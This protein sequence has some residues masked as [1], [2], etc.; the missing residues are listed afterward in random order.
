MTE[1]VASNQKVLNWN[2]KLRNQGIPC[3]RFVFLYT[4]IS[5]DDL[6]VI[7]Q[8]GIHSSCGFINSFW[9][10]LPLRKKVLAAKFYFLA[11]SSASLEVSFIKGPAS[12]S[13]RRIACSHTTY[14]GFNIFTIQLAIT[15]SIWMVPN[16]FFKENNEPLHLQI[17]IC[18]FRPSIAAG[19]SSISN[20]QSCRTH[21]TASFC[22]NQ[23]IHLPAGGSV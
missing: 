14:R 7:T 18:A 6:Q 15:A 3:I 13:E 8:R 10:E 21:L 17:D 20:P 5:W 11:W 22:W 19:S 23:T 2:L 1:Y 16:H 9:V 4:W 12:Q